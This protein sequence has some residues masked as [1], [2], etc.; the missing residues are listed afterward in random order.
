[1]ALDDDFQEFWACYPRK[2]GKLAALAAWKKLKPDEAL[3]QQ[4]IDSVEEH[5]RCK[6]WREGFICHPA[7]FIRQGRWMDELGPQDFYQARL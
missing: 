4:M 1:M 5:R 3:M 2:V 7:T 6:A